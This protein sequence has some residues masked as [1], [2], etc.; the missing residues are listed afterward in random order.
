MRT[1][2]KSETPSRF[3]V[4]NLEHTIN[5]GQVFLWKK[6]GNF[7][8][9]IDGQDI[10]RVGDAGQTVKSYSG[11][12]VDYF[13]ES[14]N[15]GRVLEQISEDQTIRDAVKKFPGLRLI[16]QDPFQCYISFIVSANSNIQNI[17][18]SL[19]RLA[20]RFGKK[21]EYDGIGFS[22]FPDP[23]SLAKATVSQL[24]SCGLGYRAGYVRAASRAVQEGTVDFDHLREA[25]YDYAKSILCGVDGIGNK[26]A[27][28]IMLFSLEK[29][30][31]F[32]LDRWMVR[33]LQ[34]YYPGR[35][36]SE[37]RTLTD[38]RYR[39]LHAELESYFGKYAGYC[40]Q[41]LFKM[42]RETNRK[43]G[44]VLTLNP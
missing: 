13:R 44:R 43:N 6:L 4:L 8:Y 24:E 27:D 29:T 5:S 16:R 9:G 26:V 40:Q 32:P 3:S 31:S 15:P 1:R 42:I 7:W 36:S 22:L 37:G 11:S 10:I 34:Q 35:F 18:S 19:Y 30:E 12:K 14:D 25:D 38:K 20:E 39:T 23:S 17:R 33:V 2:R 21:A 41:L 28:C